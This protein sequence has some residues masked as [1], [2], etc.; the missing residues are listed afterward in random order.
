[1]SSIFSYISKLSEGYATS[2]TN[3]SEPDKFEFQT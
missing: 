1:M 3:P 2:T